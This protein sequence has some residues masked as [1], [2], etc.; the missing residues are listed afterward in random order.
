[1]STVSRLDS[2][3]MFLE[4]TSSVQKALQLLDAFRGTPEPQG[5]SELAKHVG[6]PK[7]TVHRLLSSLERGAFVVRSGQLY[8]L[9]P[10]VFELGNVVAGRGPRG[11]RN[12]ALP[13]LAELYAASGHNV[14]LAVLSEGEVLYL[15]KIHGHGSVPVPSAIGGRLP[16]NCS[17]IG[18]VLMAYAR[19]GDLPS[20]NPRVARRTQYSITEPGR[21]RS[22][23]VNIRVRGEGTDLQEAALGVAC[24]AVPVFADG[25][26][27]AALSISSSTRGFIPSV[28][29]RL[30][31]EASRGITTALG[32]GSGPGG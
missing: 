10:R 22:Q 32:S 29:R 5:V 18:K 30:L 17:A 12:I 23:L 11:I 21:L 19:E 8:R 9:A 16:A 7:S 2:T 24:L 15:E 13:F 6:V 25:A 4:H 1:M 14:H 28:F 26:A 27:V 31:D 20:G 3:E